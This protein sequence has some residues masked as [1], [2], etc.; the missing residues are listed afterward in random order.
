VEKMLK[1]ICVKNRVCPLYI[2]NAIE[3]RQE[4][5]KEPKKGKLRKTNMKKKQKI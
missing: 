3:K 4:K 1:N 5:R 2:K